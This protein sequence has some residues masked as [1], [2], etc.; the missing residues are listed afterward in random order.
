M[1]P[2]GLLTLTAQP[3][4]LLRRDRAGRLPR[5]QP[6]AGHRRHRRPAAAGAAVLLRRHPADPPRR[7]E[8]PPDPDQPAAR[9][10]QRH[11]ARR[12]PPGRG[13]RRGRAV[14]AELARR[15]VPVPRRAPRTARSSRSPAR[16]AEAT[17]T[18]A[19]P[20]SYD[21][22][23]SQVAAVLAQHDAGREGA[24]RARL[25]LRARAS[26]TS[27]PSRSGS[28]SRWRTSTPTSARRSPPGSA[29]RRPEPTEP[30]VDL[31][32]SPALSQVGA[33]W[34]TDGRMVGIVVDPDG[35]LAGVEEV[36]DAVVRQPA[37]SRWSSRRTA[38]SS[39][40]GWPSSA[41]SAPPARWSSTRSSLAGSPA[42]A[43]DALV[44]RDSKAGEAGGPAVDPR[45]ALLLQECFRHAKAIGAWGAGVQAPTRPA[46]RGRG[47][48][49]WSATSPTEVFGEV[50]ALLGAH[51]VWERFGA[52]LS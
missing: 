22:H 24:H 14:P 21:D 27:R 48:G 1:Q 33:T 4:E 43:A 30:L 37:W 31:E 52:V 8:L 29:C 44:A 42:P 41:P 47:P 50:H 17:K 10:G 16:V 39:P 38:A 32:P 9:A 25:H 2:I 34:P 3:D 46:R 20:A 45:V 35:D 40:T 26:A 36:A 5:R 7:A 51:R 6:G 28:C 18:R 12:L 13:P 19:N 15:R 11:A 49:S 23:Y